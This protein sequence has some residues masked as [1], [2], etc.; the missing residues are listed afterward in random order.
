MSTLHIE[1]AISDYG[2]WKTAFDRFEVRVNNR[3]VLNGPCTDQ[4]WWWR[5]P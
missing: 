4:V 1:H 2:T 5:L 3:L